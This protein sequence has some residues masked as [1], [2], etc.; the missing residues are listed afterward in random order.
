M[1]YLVKHIIFLL[2]VISLSACSDNLQTEDDGN[3]ETGVSASVA[4]YEFGDKSTRVELSQGENGVEF[5]WSE[6]DVIAVVGYKQDAYGEKDFQMTNHTLSSFSSDRLWANF[7][8]GAFI[9]SPSATYFSFYP[10]N[11]TVTTVSS[12]QCQRYISFTGQK[13][14]GNN[15]L[16][17]LGA[18]NYMIANEVTTDESGSCAFQFQNSCCPVRF[19]LL[20]PDD[21]QGKAVTSLTVTRY[22][23]AD[24]KFVTKALQ[25]MENISSSITYQESTIDVSQT[26][27]FEECTLD[28]DHQLVAW[29]MFF[30]KDHTTG[31]TLPARYYITV[32][33]GDG[34]VYAASSAGKNMV[35]GKAYRINATMADHVVIDAKAWKIRNEGAILPY[36]LGT[37]YND[38][39]AVPESIKSQLPTVDEA[40]ALIN[41]Q[42]NEFLLGSGYDSN[43][44]LQYGLYIRAKSSDNSATPIFLPATYNDGGN[45]V[46]R[47]WLQGGE[48]Y[49]YFDANT[50]S[51][52]INSI[53]G[54]T[55]ISAAARLITT[56]E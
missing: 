21:A 15:S 8:G 7:D 35:G 33:C 31:A 56:A 54:N 37:I 16:A 18:Y 46:G 36:D 50:L 55:S 32:S 30:P 38:Y 51:A 53:E 49:L 27:N 4:K 24:H 52:C 45:H 23:N 10:Y 26:L 41:T 19:T 17:H 3:L 44:T 9:L 43:G 14:T 47:Y 42:N 48:K 39:S 6:G 11:S 5:R 1:G 20:M 22:Q 29:E 34:S 12:N 13:Q 25:K 2:A 40:T 28:S